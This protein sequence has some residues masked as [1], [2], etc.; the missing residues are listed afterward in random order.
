MYKTNFIIPSKKEEVVKET[1]NYLKDI[2]N[3]WDIIDF[4]DMES[5]EAL[6]GFFK[7]EAERLGFDVLIKEALPYPYVDINKSWDEYWSQRKSKFKKNLRRSYRLI[8]DLG[9]V[10]VSVNIYDH[11]HIDRLYEDYNRVVE[12]SMRSWKAKCGTALGSSNQLKNFYRATVDTFSKNWKIEISFLEH[13]KIPIAGTLGIV[14][15]NVWYVF[16]TFYDEKYAKFSP[17]GVLIHSVFKKMFSK[18]ISRAELLKGFFP[19]KVPWYTG[20]HNK[21]HIMVFKKTFRSAILKLSETYVRPLIS[22]SM[23]GSINAKDK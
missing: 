23:K 5:D 18:G 20:V 2:Q 19:I 13:K 11:A 8:E 16:L 9:D 1:M 21:V 3:S 7:K 22:S 15:K 14:Y 17:G 6:I 12:L 10:D 4:S